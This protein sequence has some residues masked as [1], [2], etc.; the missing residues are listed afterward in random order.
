MY[1]ITDWEESKLVR[2]GYRIA[3]DAGEILYDGKILVSD[4]ESFQVEPSIIEGPFVNILT[5]SGATI[6]FET[7]VPIKTE[8]SVGGHIFKDA[9]ANTHHEIAISMP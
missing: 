3:N 8:I 4:E 7:S 1:D 5:H 2:L 6:S 9:V